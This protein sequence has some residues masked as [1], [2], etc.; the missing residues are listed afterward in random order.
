MKY[1]PCPGNAPGPFY[2][3]AGDCLACEAPIAEAPDLMD[4]NGFPEWSS[5]CRFHRQPETDREV[6]QAIDAIP[7]CCITALRYAGD[8]KTILDRINWPEVCD[9]MPDTDP[10][11]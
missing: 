5:H 7:V 9:V 8:D 11:G 10:M 3:V 6:Q 1:Q 4:M 2:V